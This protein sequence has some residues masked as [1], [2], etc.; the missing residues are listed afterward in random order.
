MNINDIRDI[1]NDKYVVEDQS[2]LVEYGNPKQKQPIM[3]L[4]ID[5]KRVDNYLLYRFDPDDEKIFPF[6]KTHTGTNLNAICDYFLFAEIEDKLYALLI[7][8]KLGK[9]P[10]RQQ[11]LA[12]ECFMQYINKTAERLDKDTSNCEVKKVRVKNKD[13]ATTRTKGILIED[14][15]VVYHWQDFR[16]SAVISEK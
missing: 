9:K 1:L 4:K 2:K 16:I 10:S 6:F 13:K 5:D 8:L 7:E 11:L 12:S 15:I 14:G 3:S